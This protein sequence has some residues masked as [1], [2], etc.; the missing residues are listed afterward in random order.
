MHTSWNSCNNEIIHIHFSV[1][2]IFIRLPTV[3]QPLP[4]PWDNREYT[5]KGEVIKTNVGLFPKY[6]Q[7]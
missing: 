7:S 1:L 6:G 2:E 3:C 4:K 5:S